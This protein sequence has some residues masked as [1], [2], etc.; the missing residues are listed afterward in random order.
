MKARAKG[1]R[2][3]R[4]LAGRSERRTRTRTQTVGARAAARNLT[5]TSKVPIFDRRGR[6]LSV[7]GLFDE[8]VEFGEGGLRGVERHLAAR[9]VAGAKPVN[10]NRVVPIQDCP[11]LGC[12]T[13]L[14]CHEHEG[15][16]AITGRHFAATRPV[17]TRPR[18]N[19][20]G[21]NASLPA[22]PE[23][24]LILGQRTGQVWYKGPGQRR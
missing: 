13:V 1:D 15:A 12:P 11:G 23:C 6:D 3:R 14:D 8:D 2:R 19:P 17:R 9:A 18:P 24:S 10:V 7:E 5:L 16:P 4:N 22:L 20:L 21:L